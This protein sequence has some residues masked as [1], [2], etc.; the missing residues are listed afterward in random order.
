MKQGV[1]KKPEL[2]R[3]FAFSLVFLAPAARYFHKN[4][5]QI[6]NLARSKRASFGAMEHLHYG[7]LFYTKEIA[8]RLGLGYVAAC[9]VT[10]IFFPPKA[11]A[12]SSGLTPAEEDALEDRDSLQ[13]VQSIRDSREDGFKHWTKPGKIRE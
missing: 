13:Y 5:V 8:M 6:L 11:V 2:A 3:L 7:G 4:R 9:I 1:E 12:E 10:A